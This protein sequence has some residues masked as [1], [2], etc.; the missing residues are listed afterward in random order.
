MASACLPFLF[1]AVE[2]DGESYWDGGY[3]GN[4]A[5]FPLVDEC[6]AGDLGRTSNSVRTGNG[7]YRR[8]DRGSQVRS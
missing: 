1:K 8:P 3:M 7:L 4:P 6:D 2:I 5:L